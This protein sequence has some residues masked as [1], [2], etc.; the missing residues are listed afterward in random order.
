MPSIRTVLTMPA[1]ADPVECVGQFRLTPE[2]RQQCC[3]QPGAHRGQD[4]QRGFDRIWQLDRNDR[5]RRQARIDEMR[6]EIGNGAI[7]L[8][9]GQPARRLA[10]HALFVEG[11]GE[12]VRVRLA[13]DAA[14]KQIVERGGAHH[15]LD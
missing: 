3:D 13:R 14:A 9:V 10:G 8:G 7:R 1:R 5:P 6:G 15:R 4:R 2:L 12:R 11:I